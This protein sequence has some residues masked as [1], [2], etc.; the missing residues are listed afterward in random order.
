MD[1]KDVDA[2]RIAGAAVTY[3]EGYLWDG[4]EAK[5]A[6]RRA[7]DLA[8]AAGRKVAF[9]L[10]DP[11]CVD[12]HR[13]EFRELV[14]SSIDV[15]FANED[16]ITMLYQVDAFDDAARL[17]AQDCQIAAL[18]RGAKGSVVIS[19][20]ELHEIA[21]V[22]I[23]RLV[24]TTGAGDVY[25]A[26]FLYGLTRGH[27]LAMCGELGALGA[28]EVISHLGPRPEVPLAELVRRLL[29]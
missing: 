13:E 21:A 1:V 20:S 28:A 15:L 9:T 10:S 23:E 11:F 22:P 12:R 26:G 2:D 3:L 24:D 5:D 27:D 19:G 18:T 25:A 6:I 4:P 16:E 7:A 29:G 17:V 14:S 8:Q